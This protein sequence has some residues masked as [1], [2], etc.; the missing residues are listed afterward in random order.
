MGVLTKQIGNT[1]LV[2]FDNKLWVI[3]GSTNQVAYSN[4]TGTTFTAVGEARG[5]IDRSGHKCLVHGE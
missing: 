5:W 2:K 1:C 4:D 3:G